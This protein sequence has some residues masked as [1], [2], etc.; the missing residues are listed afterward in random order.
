MPYVSKNKRRYNRRRR[1]RRGRRGGRN[2]IVRMARGPFA[3]SIATKL[4]YIDIITINPGLAS[5]AGKHFSCNDL[6]DPDRTGVGHQPMGTDEYFALYSSATVVGSKITATAISGDT[7]GTAGS[8]NIGIQVQ[9]TLTSE[10]DQIVLMENSDT[11]FKS[12]APLSSNNKTTLTKRFGT[13]KFFKVK[14]ILGNETYA[15][16]AS[17]SPSEEAYYYLWAAP[18]DNASDNGAIAVRVII[19][20]LVVFHDVKLLGQS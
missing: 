10:T 7:S 15:C 8:Y 13:K 19:E 4:R 12:V 16:S 17:A 3:R 1:Y 14:D 5:A 18:F 11:T 6:Y 9:D 20:Y 2:K